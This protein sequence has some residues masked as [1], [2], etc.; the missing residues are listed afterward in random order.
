MSL[1]V[2]A[3]RGASAYELENTMEAFDKALE[4]GSHGIELDVHCSQDNELIV[5]HDNNL[6][7]LV[8]KN[9]LIQ[10]C[11]CEQ[12]L[13]YK[14]GKSCLR[15]FSKKR[16]PTLKQVI[17]WAQVNNIMLN[18]ELK[19]SI[20]AKEDVLISFLK[21]V[22]LPI[23]SHFSSFHEQL[24]VI[25][26]KYCPKIETALIVSKKFDWSKVHELQNIYTLHAHKRYY[27]EKYLNICK[28]ANVKVRF[29]GVTGGETF[30]TQPH[31]V[32]CGW[33]TDYP[34]IVKQK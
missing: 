34:D 2:F 16:M 1:P 22:K 24:L 19:D 5:F 20:L 18:I 17:H 12:L 32:V 23:G 10:A 4:I 7:R 31:S 8:G 9:A 6:K 3:H 27:K 14:L 33:I 30:L 21:E 25:V 15:I 13:H 26:K 28:E 29:Y 11:N